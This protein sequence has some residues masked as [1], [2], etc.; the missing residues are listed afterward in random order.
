M[1]A[2]P[3]NF[4]GE[5]RVILK[6]NNEPFVMQQSHAFHDECRG[7]GG[8]VMDKGMNGSAVNPL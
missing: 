6:G 3:N 7:L 8:A 5:V 2:D 1:M 4:G